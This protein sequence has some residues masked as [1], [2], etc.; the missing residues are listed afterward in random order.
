MIRLK[1]IWEKGP[2]LSEYIETEK[3]K[4]V[5]II[6]WHGLG[7]LVMFLN[8]FKKL[9]ELYPDIQIDIAV[10]KG[11]GFGEVTDSLEDT[12]V[13]FIDG[14]YL[15]KVDAGDGMGYDIVADVDFPMNEGQQVLTK[16]EWCCEKELGIELT[17]GHKK[18]TCGKNR[19]IVIHYQIT[20]LP[21]SCNPDEETAKRIWQDVIDAGYIPLEMHFQHA[22][23]NPVN[24]KFDF[25]DAT[26]RRCH[27][28]VSSLAGLI[29][30]SA[31]AICVVSGNLHVTLSVLPPQKIFFLEKDF[32]LE[33]FT[34]EADKIARANINP[35][36]YQN[37]V[38]SWLA[39]IDR[40]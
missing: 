19:L 12:I 34:K 39:G 31:G 23:H 6:F 15:K 4:K 3:P 25:I 22:F 30:N 14:D 10:Q 16:G 21:D 7:D 2:K 9:Q 20:C 35:G 1:R 11:L 28:R 13:Q 17:N 18:I 36:K 29:E 26:V 38:R 5:L 37:E 24:K 32:K 27:P 40:E 8:P 33:S